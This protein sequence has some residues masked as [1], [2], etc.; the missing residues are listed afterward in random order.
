MQAE[1]EAKFLDIDPA[2]FRKRLELAGAKLIFPERLMKRKNFDFPDNRLEKVG[3][4]V[5][6]RDEGNGKITFSYKQLV[7]RTAQGMKE[8]ETEVKSFDEACN[9][10]LA[11]GMRV[12]AYQETKREKWV[13]DD[14]EIVVDTWPWIPPFAELEA[15][16]E[17]KLERVAKKLG[18]DWKRVYHGSVEVAYQNHFD[19]TETEID[20][21]ES[22]TFIPVPEWL[23]AKRK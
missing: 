22:I 1:I 21:W 20:N 15:P 11:I 5:R 17:E 14:V 16:T 8:I 18:L 13:I 12:K 10:L 3:G 6:V 23:D 4:W 7:N 19:V 9:I 2:E